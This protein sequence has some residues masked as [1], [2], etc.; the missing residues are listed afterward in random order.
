MG[1]KRSDVRVKVIWRLH[2][3][4]DSHGDHRYGLRIGG[5][6][7]VKGYGGFSTRIVLP[8]DIQ[9]SDS[10]GPVIPPNTAVTAGDWMNFSGTFGD[11]VS[12]FAILVH[13]SHPGHPRPWIL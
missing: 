4:E 12:N 2:L 9:T 11:T 5:S 6:S 8:A 1:P 13:P 3:D 7:D 10:N